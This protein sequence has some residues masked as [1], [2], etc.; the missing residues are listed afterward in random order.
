[1]AALYSPCEVHTVVRD[2]RLRLSKKPNIRSED[3]FASP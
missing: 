2:T 3:L 1:M